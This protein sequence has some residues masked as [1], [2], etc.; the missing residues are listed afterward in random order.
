MSVSVQAVLSLAQRKFDASNAHA[1]A[2]RKL[3]SRSPGLSTF[4]LLQWR[5]IVWNDLRLASAMLEQPLLPFSPRNASARLPSNLTDQAH[6]LALATNQLVPT[7]PRLSTKAAYD[8]FL[9]LHQICL[10]LGM[11]LVEE[12]QTLAIENVYYGTAYQLCLMTADVRSIDPRPFSASD[13]LV[14]CAAS[15]MWSCVPS[16]V[17]YRIIFPSVVEIIQSQLLGQLYERLVHEVDLVGSWRDQARLESLLWVLFVGTIAANTTSSDNNP[18]MPQPARPWFGKALREIMVELQVHS[19]GDLERALRLF[20]W[21]TPFSSGDCR[22]LWNKVAL[23]DFEDAS[24]FYASGM[25][26]GDL[27][28]V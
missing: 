7:S 17:S 6:V 13:S 12:K 15:F 2:G 20:P 19:V 23:S 5:H 28:T 3:I 25:S 27:R 16:F 9:G 18:W 14:L 11:P 10:A 24:A 22:M 21:A 1:Q 4:R 26:V 8:L